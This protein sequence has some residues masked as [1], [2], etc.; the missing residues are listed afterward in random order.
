M[1][2]THTPWFILHSPEIGRAFQDLSDLCNDD[3]VLDRKTKAI[4]M[5]AAASLMQRRDR[6]EDRLRGA[7]D[8]GVSKAEMTETLL[9]MAFLIAETHL[10]QAA[11]LYRKYIG[12]SNGHSG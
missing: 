9:I 3:G 4:L 12:D 10:Q 7:L 6:I 2:R 8:A 5:L 11:N 1:I